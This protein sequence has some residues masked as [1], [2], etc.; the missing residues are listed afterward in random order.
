MRRTTIYTIALLLFVFLGTSGAALMAT[1][2]GPY[3]TNRPQFSSPGGYEYFN[4]AT[5]TFSAHKGVDVAAQLPN[6]TDDPALLP[7]KV[8]SVG[9]FT[10]T[11]DV[12]PLGTFALK[13]GSIWRI[14]SNT[15][16]ISFPADS[17]T[18]L[19]PRCDRFDNDQMRYYLYAYDN[20]SYPNPVELAFETST[21]PPEV[22]LRHK[23]DDNSRLYIGTFR[24][25]G[26]IVDQFT[27][28][29]GVYSMGAT[30]AL[31]F[32]DAS[33]PKSYEPLDLVARTPFSP[34]SY[35]ISA[36]AKI[37][38]GRLEYQFPTMFDALYISP[39]C[40][41][42]HTIISPAN[43]NYNRQTIQFN[44]I[45]GTVPC[46]YASSGG[47]QGYLYITGFIE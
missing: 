43:A 11:L 41:A 29:D 13:N 30:P 15:K 16:V 24:N 6:E 40:Q 32:A 14:I 39:D 31:V 2:K 37:V 22:G 42:D 45:P 3:S 28:R 20:S 9:R 33:V 7:Q 23:L 4:S 47:T 34:G 12:G 46:Y 17:R 19:C 38:F 8:L 18:E 44:V 36:N 26:M 1:Q 5:S 27:Y 10:T 35:I 25:S 21:T